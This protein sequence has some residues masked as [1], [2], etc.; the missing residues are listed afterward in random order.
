MS[1]AGRK[2]AYLN[3]ACKLSNTLLKLKINTQRLSVANQAQV[4][5]IFYTN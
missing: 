1:E 3:K 5:R 2:F 4:A